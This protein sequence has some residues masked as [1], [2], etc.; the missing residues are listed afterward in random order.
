M[1]SM[2]QATV[3]TKRLIVLNKYICFGHISLAF[4]IK[5]HVKNS[6]STNIFPCLAK[7]EPDWKFALF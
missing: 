3:L 7:K 5:F 1:F 2:L 4:A 6:A